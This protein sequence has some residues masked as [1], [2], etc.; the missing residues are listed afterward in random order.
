MTAH[1]LQLS[2]GPVQEFI[3]AARRTRDLWF[4]SYLLSEISKAAARAVQD[5]GGNLIFPA[6]NAGDLERGSSLNVANIILAEVHDRDPGIIARSAGEAARARWK[7]FAEKVLSTYSAILHKNIWMEQVDDVVEFYAAWVPFT[8]EN[9]AARRQR[10]VRL[11]AGR[12]N[13]RDFL[14]TA[15]DRTGVPKSSLDGLRETVLTEDRSA[16]HA[17]FRHALRVR[18]GEQLDVVGLVKRTAEGHMPY[19]SVSRIAADPWLRGIAASESGRQVL[20]ELRDA[21]A[22]LEGEKLVHRINVERQHADYKLFPYEGTTLY[23]T[24]HHELWEE[25]GEPME[26]F[27]S[28]GEALRKVEQHARQAGL[29]SE[30]DPYLAVLVADGDQMGKAIAGLTDSQQHRTFSRELSAFVTEAGTVVREHHGVLVYSGGDDVLA[31]VPVDRCLACARRLHTVFGSAM[32]KA[33]AGV[34]VSKPT[35]SVG[36]ALGHFL[37]DLEDLLGYGRAAEKAAKKPDRD[38]LAVHLHKR[39]GAPVRVRKPWAEKLD[40]TEKL[41]ERLADYARW[42]LKGAVSSRIPYELH[43][44]ADLYDDWPVATRKDAV[45]RDAFRVIEK[46]RPS[47]EKTEEMQEIR[48]AVKGRVN[49]AGDLRDFAGELLI[50]RQLAV[51]LRQSGGGRKQ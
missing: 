36:L 5:H 20:G 34:D 6:P 26:R 39:G 48:D 42:F 30:P 22:N 7:E 8:A 44:L 46:K 47:G 24:R 17:R 18:F 1:L 28:L 19:P 2:V 35:L 25:T 4:G 12:K 50:A 16:W 45:Q 38:G 9:Y 27:A 32:D 11:L 15:K 49:G 21:C 29:G 31:F 43:R 14:Q 10:L 13:C 33:L 3:A 40:E 23:R 51:A 37:E 41:D